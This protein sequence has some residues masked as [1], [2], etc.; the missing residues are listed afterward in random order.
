MK[1]ILIAWHIYNF[2]KLELFK[3]ICLPHRVALHL[4]VH[5]CMRE[6]HQSEVVDGLCSLQVVEV[7]CHGYEQG[8][9]VPA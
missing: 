1:K 2:L 9:S 4:A 3:I 8:Y 6:H 7:H 5:C